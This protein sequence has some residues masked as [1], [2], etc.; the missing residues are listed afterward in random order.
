MPVRKQ[1]KGWSGQRQAMLQEDS[2]K[3][4]HPTTLLQEHLTWGSIHL[5]RFNVNVHNTKVHFQNVLVGNH[6]VFNHLQIWAMSICK[7]Q[8]SNRSGLQ[9]GSFFFKETGRNVTKHK[10]ILVNTLSQPQ[11]KS[12]DYD[13][14]SCL[15]IKRAK[16]KMPC[17]TIPQKIFMCRTPAKCN[18][19]S[20]FLCQT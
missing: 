8:S 4:L 19:C 7:L 2:V 10:V 3:T 13:G 20:F 16:L 17:P 14:Q 12:V 5:V 11:K 1:I 9:I 18:L 15:K 6:C